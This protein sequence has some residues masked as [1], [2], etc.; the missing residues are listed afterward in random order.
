MPRGTKPVVGNISADS[1]TY[2][3]DKVGAMMLIYGAD[4]VLTTGWLRQG[5]G[6]LR[7]KVHI[8]TFTARRDGP[9]AW[10]AVSGTALTP[11]AT[12]TG[13]GYFENQSLATLGVGKMW[14][15]VA[16]AAGLSAAGPGQAESCF[17]SFAESKARVVASE[18]FQVE[19]DT[20]STK[21][22]VFV[23]GPPVPALGLTGALVAGT[24]SGINGTLKMSFVWRE[25]TSPDLAGP[26]AWSA[27]LI[28]DTAIT[29]D[30]DFNSSNM[31]ITP[32]SGKAY[33]Q[34][35]LSITSSDARA[36]LDLTLAVKY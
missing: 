31:V 9:D 4:N 15:Q 13:G 16:M 25:F 17:S 22:S 6:N 5:T 8:R 10:A 11:S 2:L 21:T 33:V 28:T 23:F 12:P 36:T 7:G 14:A 19:P 27:G 32:T 30:G 20:N 29:T 3:V 26:G 34:L 1:L 24:V 35:G 18:T